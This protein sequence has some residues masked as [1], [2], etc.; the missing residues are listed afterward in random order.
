MNVPV[1]IYSTSKFK[2][3]LFTVPKETLIIRLR[4]INFRKNRLFHAN[5][6]FIFSFELHNVFLIMQEEKIRQNQ[7]NYLKNSGNYD[8]MV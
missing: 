2:S 8:T 3:N 1:K 4:K 5:A 7:K 6:K